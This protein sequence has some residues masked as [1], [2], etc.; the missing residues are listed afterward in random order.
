MGRDRFDRNQIVGVVKVRLFIRPGAAWPDGST[1]KPCIRLIA[2]LKFRKSVI[3][4]ELLHNRR[5]VDR[6][7][8]A[9]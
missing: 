2:D 1:G 7:A 4:D 6:F 9:G 5:L 3:A 8:S